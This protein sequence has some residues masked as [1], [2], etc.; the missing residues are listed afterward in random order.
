MIRPVIATGALAVAALFVTPAFAAASQDIA[1][2]KIAGTGSELYVVNA[3]GSGLTRV[4][5]NKKGYVS[6]LDMSPAGNELAFVERVSGSPSV[7]KR[8]RLKDSG[9]ADGAPVAV[10][11]LCG[12][13]YVD[14]NPADPGL[15]LVSGACS[16]HLY[17][18]TIRTDG[19]GYSELQTGNAN[20]YVSEARWLNDGASYV[21]VR[22]VVAGTQQLCRNACDES[23]GDLLW[24]DTQIVW[25]D[26]ARTSDTVIYTDNVGNMKLIDVATR[27]D[28]TPTPFLSGTS[29]HYSPSDDYIVYRSPHK[30]GGD[31]VLIYDVATG[32]SSRLSGKGSWGSVDW[33][34]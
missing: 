5:S 21:Y 26:V 6:Q 34:P 32:L 30:A 1:Y 10:P 19:S 11:N 28:V 2:V 24:S 8:Q 22:S 23:A 27:S 4:Y 25:N 7:L 14:Y 29:G 31:Y 13:D 20:L 3:N 15:L 17:I 12:P 9:A 16:G 33:R 18:A